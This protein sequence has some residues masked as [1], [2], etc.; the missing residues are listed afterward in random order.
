MITLNRILIM[1]IPEPLHAYDKLT[2][3]VVADSKH[4][5]TFLLKDR[6]VTPLAEI[7]N[8]FPLKD[9]EKSKEAE[10]MSPGGIR[11]GHT[12]E[13]LDLEKER[14]FSHTLA[15]ELM[16]RLQEKTFEDLILAAP[17]EHLNEIVKAL[18]N[19][20]RARLVTSI[21]KLLTNEPVQDILA[22]INQEA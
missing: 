1:Q 15:T 16:H 10:T 8:D 12:E 9:N 13:K 3:L 2:L 6:E 5:K 11:S 19:D 20:V 22:R 7:L 21:P 17:Q 14:H 4:A 18:H